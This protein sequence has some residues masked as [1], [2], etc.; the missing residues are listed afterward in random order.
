MAGF[1]RQLG[2]SEQLKTFQRKGRR[3]KLKNCVLLELSIFCVCVTNKGII[4][5][6]PSGEIQFVL[7]IL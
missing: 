5:F 4:E 3:Y 1:S 7:C 2:N 6:S